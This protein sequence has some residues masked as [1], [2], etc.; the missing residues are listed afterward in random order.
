MKPLSGKVLAEPAVAEQ[1]A[2]P[3]PRPAIPTLATALAA[4]RFRGRQTDCGDFG[5][6][7][8][9]DGTWFYHGSPI[10]RKPL[11]RLLSTALHRDA[12]GGFW[13]ITPAERGRI[14]VEDAPFLA[15]AL[16]CMGAPGPNQTLVFA[17]DLGE[18][19]VVDRGHP[20]RV[21]EEPATGEPA[22]Y[23]EVRDQLEARI[24]R[25]VFYQLVELGV[26]AGNG[27]LGVWSAGTMFEI[28]RMT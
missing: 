2:D 28:G 5:I 16:D 25:A 15:V 24:A 26:D 12:Q 10:S 19:V 23:V 7:I 14:Q 11:V 3:T 1:P 8:A 13:L 6:R 4:A 21:V 9:R 27:R 18:R 20:I 22:P 17:T